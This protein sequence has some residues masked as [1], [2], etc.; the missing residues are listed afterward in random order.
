MRLDYLYEKLGRRTPPSLDLEALIA[1]YRAGNAALTA[2]WRKRFPGAESAVLE[3]VVRAS[4]QARRRL[5]RYGEFA[6]FRGP[7]GVL[8]ER[9]LTS[10]DDILDF[11]MIEIGAAAARAGVTDIEWR[12]LTV[13]EALTPPP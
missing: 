7:P 2:D 13:A 9:Q 4:G 6:G 1:R 5:R 10:F 3:V 12:L 11:K 8:I